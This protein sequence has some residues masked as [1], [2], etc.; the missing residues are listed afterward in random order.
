[1]VEQSDEPGQQARLVANGARVTRECMVESANW[2]HTHRARR[3][4]T[5]HLQK[6][7]AEPIS[8]TRPQ[9]DPLTGG[10]A[11]DGAVRL[12]GHRVDHACPQRIPCDTTLASVGTAS[13]MPARAPEAGPLARRAL[14]NL[15]PPR[16]VDLDQSAPTSRRYR[17]P[18]LPPSSEGSAAPASLKPALISN[19]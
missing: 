12:G 7:F 14:V 18:C 8:D 4:V 5:A 2:R 9:A 16:E 15:C 6:A 17:T 19:L 13:P 3:A 10:G 11:A 1:V